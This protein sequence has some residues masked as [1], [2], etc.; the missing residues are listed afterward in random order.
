MQ[1][2]K[3]SVFF[4]ALAAVLALTA[5]GLFI[6]RTSALR[7]S[8]QAQA[9]PEPSTVAA[10]AGV[11]PA[12]AERPPA[13]ADKASPTAPP[14]PHDG[15]ATPPANLPAVAVAKVDPKQLVTEVVKSLETA[16][17]DGLARML[18]KD[19]CDAKTI[20]LLKTLASS[21]PIKIKAQ[22]GIR[23]VGELELNAL[24]RW[25]LT[26]EGAEPGRDHIFLDLRNANGKWSIAKITL[27]AL[28]EQVLPATLTGDSLA[29]ADAFIQAVL[30]LNFEIARGFVDSKSLS[31][32]KIAALCIL[33]EEGKYQLRPT[34][35]LRAMFHR[36][37]TIGYL[38]NLQTPDASQ[39][40]QFALNLRRAPAQ[41]KWRITEI[42]L[43]QLLADYASRVAGGDVYYSPLVKNP[44][45]GDTLALYF[46]FDEDQIN[47]RTRR[48]LQ[49]VSHILRA[50]PAKKITLSGYT[51]ALGTIHY[52]NQLSARRAATVRDFLAAAGVAPS[53]IVTFAKGASQ[54]RRPNVT[55]TGH[56]DPVGRRANRRTEIYLDF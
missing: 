18:G 31:E 11:A 16:D 42:N 54:P 10:A 3:V 43:D 35:P 9:L 20:E 12:P 29:I 45:G 36:G 25:S 17:Y 26:L 32:T 30:L 37:D 48:Q 27:P 6:Y 13:T 8:Q 1:R 40:A 55:A 41:E 33:F 21:H 7:E 22:N 52:N 5:I 2:F 47:P 46:E 50:D 23:E 51:D 56:D 19:A 34:K 53:Q 15:Q 14:M 38:A 44:Q 24:S 4:L 39:T 28:P 49:I